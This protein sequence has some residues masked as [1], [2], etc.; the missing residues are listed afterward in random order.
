MAQNPRFPARIAGEQSSTVSNWQ[1]QLMAS[2]PSLLT[3]HHLLS[4]NVAAQLAGML[5][6]RTAATIAAAKISLGMVIFTATV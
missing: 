5:Q 2:P 4:P 3:A 6:H 1:F